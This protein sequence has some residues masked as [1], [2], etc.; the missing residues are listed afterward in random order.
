MPKRKEYEMAIKIAGEIEKSFYESTKLTQKELSALAK[1]AAR[2]AAAAEN[3]SGMTLKSFRKDLADAAPA[4]QQLE[5]VSDAAF[6]A[7]KTG[8]AAAAAAVAAVTTASFSVGAGFEEQMSAVQAISMSSREEMELLN[9][10]A[11]ELGEST[12]FSAAEV[13]QGLEYMAMAGWKTEDMMAGIDGVLNLAAASGE[14]LGEVSD[15]VTDAMTAFGMGTDQVER[16]ADVL[17]AASSNS[18]TNVSMMGETFKYVAPV[19]GALGYE[20]EDTAVAIGLMANSGIKASQAGTALR[21]MM[22]RMTKPTKEVQTAMDMLNLSLTDGDGNMKSFLEIQKD[23]REGFRG[24]SE[25]QAA[26]TAS[27]LAGQ[28]AMSGLLAIVNASDEDFDKMT[29]AIG[30]SAGAAERMAGIRLDN[31]KGDMTILQSAAEGFGI[32][33]YENL[34]GPARE[35]VQYGTE[36]IGDMTKEIGSKFP[37]ARREVLEFAESMRSMAEPLLKVGGWF[38]DNPGAI[39]GPIAGIGTAVTV[40]KAASGVMSLASALGK[41]NPVGMGIMALGGVV[42]VITGIGTAIKKSAEDAKRANLE[43]HFGDISL[44]LKELQEVASYVVANESLDK[45]RESVAA[46]EELD[47]IEEQIDSAARAL[48][49]MDWK[50]SIGMELTADEQSDYIGQIEAYVNATQEYVSQQHYAVTLSIETLLGDNADGSRLVDEMNMF[51]AGQSAE[52]ARIG[53]ELNE[54]TTEAFN[55]GLLDPEE[56]EII[57]N[58]KG[59]MAKIRAEMAGSDL[60]AGFDLLKMKYGGVELDADSFQNLQAEI[61]AQVDQSTEA[62]DQAYVEAMSELRRQSKIEG[63]SQEK[64]DES[65]AEINQGYLQQKAWAQEKAVQFQVD[66]IS[67]NYPELEKE[68]G[69]L[70]EAV[71]SETME[72]FQAAQ[73]QGFYGQNIP[74]IDQFVQSKA[75]INIDDATKDAMQELYEYL[76]PSIQQLEETKSQAIEMGAEL[77]EGINEGLQNANALGAISGSTDAMWA[78]IGQET[79]SPEYKEMLQAMVDSGAMI[80]EEFNNGIRQNLG[81]V[82]GTLT[83]MYQTAQ[84]AVSGSVSGKSSMASGRK[85]RSNIASRIGSGLVEHGDGGIFSVPHIAWVA[86]QGTE[87]IIPIDGSGESINMWLKTGELL[88]IDGL[89]G[90]ED[91]VSAGVSE[92][93][94]MGGMGPSVVYNPVVNFYGDSVSRDDVEEIMETEQERFDRLY[95]RYNRDMIRQS[96]R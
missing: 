12:S 17:A 96:F 64:F 11:K 94:V 81:I 52:L 35:L 39:A 66:M 70:Q 28:E 42:A 26:E 63:W 31:L 36:F 40:Y 44:S 14:E 37:T 19:A 58:L 95:A 68:L 91:P 4:F 89:T 53:K 23:I 2:T 84:N 80:P 71:S 6:G 56:A 88:G 7:I 21:S 75:N 5:R 62:Y 29:V 10:K 85:K 83:E 59:D 78:L 76:Q 49:K 74:Y 27:M 32:E 3:A 47:G 60:E 1:Q 86:E 8:A 54:V 45:I 30:N 90:G 41:L 18:N 48:N 20:V 93:A 22:S 55:D 38:L 57:A 69:K 82:E 9:K 33:L 79:E 73:E 34:S 61:Q 65:V 77:P 51:Y 92:M 16:F 46:M 13:G 67:G 87:S 15:I 24:M 50:V 72:V 43:D 25:A